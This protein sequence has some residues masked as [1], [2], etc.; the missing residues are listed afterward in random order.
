MSEFV[1]GKMLTYEDIA[2]ANAT[3]KTMDIKGKDY[4]EV[5]Q[6]IKAFRMVFP[7][8]FIRT[9]MMSN[10]NGI[11][12]FRASVGYIDA[13]GNPC[14]IGTGTAYEREDSSYINKT[15]YIENCETS[16]VGRA[17]GMAGFGIDTSVASAEE[18][19]NAIANQK[20]EKAPKA[21]KTETKTATAK[22]IE[23]LSKVYTGDNLQ[24]LLEANGIDKIEALPMTK[25][26]ELIAKLANRKQK[27]E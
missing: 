10:E 5:N 13:S 15:S 18:V 4:A 21:E 19:Q 12:V 7:L 9:E 1:G 20:P 23:I 2:K 14:E 27:G 22:Q 6:R 11:C 17:L 26:S 3:I 24:K 16:A 25:A 8:G